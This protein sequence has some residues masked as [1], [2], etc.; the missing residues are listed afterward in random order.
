ML[1]EICVWH[2]LHLDD[3]VRE[4]VWVKHGCRTELCCANNVSDAALN[5]I[6]SI[7]G[8]RDVAYIKTII[9][10]VKVGSEHVQPAS[11]GG[12]ELWDPYMF[13]LGDHVC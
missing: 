13:G 4:L 11:D 6:F 7:C 10:H 12:I 8:G 3:T 5:Q 1:L 2:V 9:Y